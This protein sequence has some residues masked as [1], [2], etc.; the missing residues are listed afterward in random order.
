MRFWV[1]YCFVFVFSTSIAQVPMQDWRLF[2]PPSKAQK[3]AASSTHVYAILGNGLFEQ[4]IDGDDNFLWTAANYLSDINLSSIY[5]DAP[6]QTLFVGY[7]NGNL[8][9]IK[10]NTLTNLPALLLSNVLGNKHY[11]KFVRE[12]EFIYASTGIG[13]LK[14]DPLKQEIRD[15][16][17][18]FPTS[19]AILDVSFIG[20]TIF[21]L[22]S[23]QIRYGIKNNIALADFSQWTTLQNVP[24]QTTGSFTELINFNNKLH[25]S[26]RHT[27]HQ[28]DTLY[29]RETN[30]FTSITSLLDNKILS[31]S[32]YNNHLIVS[33]DGSVYDV[34]TDYTLIEQ[35]FQY[36]IGEFVHANQAIKIGLDYWIADN[37]H[38]L[39]KARNSF[40]NEKFGFAGPAS[41]N[42]YRMDWK[43]GKL[44]IAGGGLTGNQ[45]TY[46]LA[47]LHLFEDEKWS[48]INSSNQPEMATD[49]WDILSVSIDPADI[50]H[51]AFGTYS[52]RALFETTDGKTIDAWYNDE[53]SILERTTLGNNL[54]DVSNLFFDN[55][56]NLWIGQSYSNFPLKVKTKSGSWHQF[57]LGSA[58][59]AKVIYDLKVDF[60]G[61]KWLATSGAGLVAFTDNGTLED[62]SDDQFKNLMIGENSGNLPSNVVRTICVDFNNDIWLGTDAGL[63]V[64]YNANSVFNNPNSTINAQQI[65]IEDGEFVEILLGESVITK[66][67]LDGGNRKWIGTE[68]SGVFLLSPDGREEI[69]RFTAENSPLISNQIMDISINETTGEVYFITDKGLIS[70]RSD[71][72]LGDN[73]YENVTVFP[74]PVRPDYFGVVTIQGIAHNSSV[75]ITDTGG[76]LVYQTIA[77]GGTATWN[78]QTMQGERVKTGVYL[79]W[80]ASTSGKARKVGKVVFIN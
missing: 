13:I 71:A 21:A 1:F 24:T 78:G 23:N 55:Q 6:S 54:H 35:I 57:D 40:L 32:P 76:Q 16:Y 18:P 34:G 80:T 77:N 43:K 52:G 51:I 17:Y 67:A 60:N 37:N 61:V 39:V 65:L 56:S 69:Y 45:S 10:N 8:D 75:K 3:I 68:A 46:N 74:N 33:C 72:S 25:L 20:D 26:Y 48:V 53:N 31:L 5:F 30:N 12:G 73:T 42:Y 4:Q 70:F 41:N 7:A 59:K 62:P 9:L 19:T 28:L 47:G 49:A 36:N 29:V 11:T 64:I 14:I 50:N 63:A 58:P 38:G 44:A 2:T 22:S 15:T 27:E 79:I 66:I